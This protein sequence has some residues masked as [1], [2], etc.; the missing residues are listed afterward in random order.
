L[1][2]SLKHSLLSD[3]TYW[4]SI[5]EASFPF[6]AVVEHTNF[7]E[8]RYYNNE[9][10]VYFGNY[11]PHDHKYYK[12]SAGDLVDEFLPYI[13]KM[14]RGFKKSWINKAY[15]FKG[16]YAQPIVSLNYSEMIPSIETPI[17]GLYLANMQQVYPW[18]RGTNY[19]VEQGFQVADLVMKSG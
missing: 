19:A 2:L 17:K 6:L 9:N 3:G 13:L 5:N 4:L 16:Y 14:N 18:D 10:L 8:K 12:K 11:L 7:V 1:V 15:L